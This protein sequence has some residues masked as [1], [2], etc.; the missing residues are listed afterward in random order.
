MLE[1]LTTYSIAEILIF[2]FMLAIAL[3]IYACL[4]NHKDDSSYMFL[5]CT[6]IV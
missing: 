5:L 2:V 6:S 3:G 4:K 1:L